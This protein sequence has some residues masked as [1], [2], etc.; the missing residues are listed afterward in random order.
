MHVRSGK[1]ISVNVPASGLV[2]ALEP[3]LRACGGTW[4]AHGSGDADMEAVDANDRLAVPP[5]DPHYMLRRVWLSKEEEEGYYYGFA[6]EGLVAAVPH[7][8]H[9]A[10][11]PRATIGSITRK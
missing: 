10:P 9:P 6:N 5:D 3:V 8:P 11:V 7:R 4:V 2:T 1:S